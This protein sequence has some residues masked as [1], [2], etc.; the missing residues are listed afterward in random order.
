MSG[1]NGDLDNH[2]QAFLDHVAATRAPNTVKG[3]GSDLAQLAKSLDGE[4]DFTT[5]SLKKYLRKYARTPVT[6]AR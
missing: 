3:Y 1:G 2:I 4:F 6:R 5:D